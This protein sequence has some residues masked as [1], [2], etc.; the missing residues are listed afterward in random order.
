MSC[1]C[2]QRPSIVYLQVV[3]DPLQ[4]SGPLQS[5]QVK[6]K[7]ATAWIIRYHRWPYHLIARYRPSAAAR[8]DG[9]MYQKGPEVVFVSRFHLPFSV[10]ML[11]SFTSIRGRDMHDGADSLNG[12]ISHMLQMSSQASIPNPGF[13]VLS[14]SPSSKQRYLPFDWKAGLLINFSQTSSP[15]PHAFLFKCNYMSQIIIEKFQK[16]GL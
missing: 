7:W 6:G 15:A 13:C 4:R 5:C 9:R 3:G 11:L 1:S 8:Q 14:Y 12:F 2:M 10:T 16:L